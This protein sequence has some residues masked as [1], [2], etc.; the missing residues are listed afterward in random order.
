MLPFDIYLP[1]E[2]VIIEFDGMK[3]FISIDYFGGEEGF[4]EINLHNNLKNSFCKN[5]NIPILRIPYIYSTVMDKEYFKTLVL[6][7]IKTKTV[8]Q[9]IL[10]Y[11]SQYKFSN[12]VECVKEFNEKA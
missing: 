7:S 4:K 5:N 8:P 11:Y 9:E 3:S 12:Y 1:D 10:D 6:D 2:N